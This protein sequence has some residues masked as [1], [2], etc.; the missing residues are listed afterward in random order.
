MQDAFNVKPP[1]TLLP[2]LERLLA[3]RPPHVADAIRR[4]FSDVRPC[5]IVESARANKVPIR[6]RWL[7]RLRRQPPPPP[8]LSPTVSKF[9]GVPYLESAEPVEKYRFIGQINFAEVSEALSREGFP[10]PAGMPR[11]GLLTVYMST[12]AF[13]GKLYWYPAPDESKAVRTTVK[14]A[15]KYEAQLHF[16]GG[17]SLRGLDYY[18]GVPKHDKELW[19]YINELEIPAVDTDYSPHLFG[20]TCDSLNDHYGLTPVAGRSNSIRDY[21]LIW[22]IDG[23]SPA[24]LD[25]GSNCLYV[26][27]HREDL[28]RGAFE[29]AI[30]T[31]ANT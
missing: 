18:G 2:D 14:C 11:V 27:I 10:A 16:R 19:N 7:D 17:W 13:D 9:G 20:H 29:N 28:A 23:D 15:S 5:A 4:T 30:L 24:G 26:V 25:W 8:V 22:R 1:P 6:G 3:T 31:G 21:A 12:T